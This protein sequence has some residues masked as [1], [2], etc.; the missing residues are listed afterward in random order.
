MRSATDRASKDD[1][2]L[3]KESSLVRFGV[4]PEEADKLPSESVFGG[5]T[6]RSGPPWK[7][8]RGDCNGQRHALCLSDACLHRSKPKSGILVGIGS[9]ALSGCEIC[10]GNETDLRVQIVQQGGEFVRAHRVTP[11][12][13]LPQTAID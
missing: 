8:G 9:I 6:E 13:R 7:R 11:W 4:R 12:A 10:L 1:E 2:E 3:N 5:T